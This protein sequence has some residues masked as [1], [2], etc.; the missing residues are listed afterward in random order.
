MN[1]IKNILSKHSSLFL[2]GII[3]G[4]VVNTGIRMVLAQ[5]NNSTISACV[6]KAGLV[7]IVDQNTACRNDETA[8]SWNSQGQPAPQGLPLI[9]PNCNIDILN[10]HGNDLNDRLAGKDYTNALLQGAQMDQVNFSNSN[11]TGAY[12]KLIN[13]SNANLAGVNFTNAVLEGANLS[14]A[15]LTGANMTGTDLSNFD[16]LHHTK[17]SGAVV[18]NVIWSNTTCPN[19]LNSNDLGG[20]CVGTF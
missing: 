3:V 1:T 14:G 17:M 10:S 12:L 9:C 11:F 15:D 2:G 7:R 4:L 19:G 6:N 16:G 5:T 13:L 18:T 8:L 20:T